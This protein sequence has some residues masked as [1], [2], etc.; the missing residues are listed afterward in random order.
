MVGRLSHLERLSQLE[1]QC[2]FG[3]QHNVF[4]A[5][6]SRSC[7]SS[8][9]ACQGANS[10]AFS[11]AGKATNQR[12]QSRA[13]TGHHQAALAFAR[14]AARNRGGLDIHVI[15]VYVHR[16]KADLEKGSSL[17]SSERMRCDHRSVRR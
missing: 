9:S 1:G 15:T 17:E 10:S 14:H 13:S 5:R 4:V 12:S 6:K 16:I 2:A 7:R 3:R 8:A 11:A